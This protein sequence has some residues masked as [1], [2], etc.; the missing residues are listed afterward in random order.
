MN[1]ND[2]KMFGVICSGLWLFVSGFFA[3]TM[4]LFAPNP[5]YEL[6]RNI[7][8]L[9]IVFGLGPVIGFALKMIGQGHP[10]GSAQLIG[11]GIC[12]AIPFLCF[13]LL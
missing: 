7:L 9:Y 4:A 13:L 12:A 5:G 1:L 2:W 8:P 3:A 10:L 11:L 6:L